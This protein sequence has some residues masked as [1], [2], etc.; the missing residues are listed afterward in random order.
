M[1][2]TTNPDPAGTLPFSSS[3]RTPYREKESTYETEEVEESISNHKI[4]RRTYPHTIEDCNWWLLNQNGWEQ[5]TKMKK[6][7][8][9]EEEENLQ[10]EQEDSYPQY[11][12]ANPMGEKPDLQ[13]KLKLRSCQWIWWLDDLKKIIGII[14]FQVR[15]FS[16]LRER[17]RVVE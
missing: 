3:Q 8:G 2:Q 11:K 9:N 12:K 5:K 4:W 10:W 16:A 7:R 1:K 6:G 13:R 14:G 17:E 15:E